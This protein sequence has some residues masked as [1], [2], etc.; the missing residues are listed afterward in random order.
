MFLKHC[1]YLSLHTLCKTF[2]GISKTRLIIF[3]ERDLYKR[4]VYKISTRV[5]SYVYSVQKDPVRIDC[6]LYNT[7]HLFQK[8]YVGFRKDEHIYI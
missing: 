3:L 6:I 8:G 7:N 2:G 1:E 4:N 5:R